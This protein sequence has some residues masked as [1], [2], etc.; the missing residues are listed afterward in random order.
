MRIEVKGHS[1]RE[2]LTEFTKLIGD[3]SEFQSITMEGYWNGTC[4]LVH[5]R[6]SRICKPL[7]VRHSS[8]ARSV[9]GTV[10]PNRSCIGKVQR[11]I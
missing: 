10:D 9:D 11:H 8:S 2:A 6:F 5:P 3:S 4:V 7:I 1:R